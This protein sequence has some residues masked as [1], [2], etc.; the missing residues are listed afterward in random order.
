MAQCVFGGWVYIMLDM[1]IGQ[2]SNTTFPE[3]V[4]YGFLDEIQFTVSAHFPALAFW[5]R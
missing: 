4:V 3:V 5:A 2:L 1:W